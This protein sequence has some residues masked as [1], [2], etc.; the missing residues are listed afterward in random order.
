MVPADFSVFVHLVRL[1]IA[2]LSVF[3]AK[4][5]KENGLEVGLLKRGK[6]RGTK[7]SEGTSVQENLMRASVG[8]KVYVSI[9]RGKTCRTQG[10]KF[11][12]KRKI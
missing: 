10:Q 5:K 3:L 8:K 2:D 6:N 9:V 7:F 11:I 12:H 1:C 4:I